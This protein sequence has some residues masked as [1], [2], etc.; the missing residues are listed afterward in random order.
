MAG[1][2]RIKKTAAAAAETETVESM[3]IDS[4]AVVDIITPTRADDIVMEG[5][6]DRY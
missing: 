4:V 6:D 3:E 2:N 1:I 5:C